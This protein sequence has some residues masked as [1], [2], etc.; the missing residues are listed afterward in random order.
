M[1]GINVHHGEDV[2]NLQRL[3]SDLEK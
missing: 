3:N 1:F 2:I